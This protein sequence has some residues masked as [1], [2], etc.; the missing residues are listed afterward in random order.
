MKILLKEIEKNEAKKKIGTNEDKNN[1]IPTFL[2]G[3][4]WGRCLL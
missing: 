2:L 3:K 4:P 1:I